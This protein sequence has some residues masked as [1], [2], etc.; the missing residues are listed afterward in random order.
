[1]ADAVVEQTNQSKAKVFISYSRKDIE[2][3][4]R[5]E[6]ALKA[7]GFE[8]LIDRQDPIALQDWSK[9]IAPFEDW[10]KRIEAL[11]GKADTIVFV[12][13]PDSVASKVALNEINYGKL[14]NKRFAPVV[15]RRVDNNAV[16]EA[17]RS[18][19]YIFFDDSSRFDADADHL[20][21]VL[22]VDLDWI[23]KHTEYGETARRWATAGRPG[24]GGLLLRSP[25]LEEAERWIAA[26]PQS[27]PAPTEETVAFV[28]ESRRGAIW[29]RRRAMALAG[30]VAL[31]IA[32]GL[33]A[34]WQ[35]VW[36]KE[37]IYVLADVYPLKTARERALKPMETFKECTDCPEMLM[38]PAGSFMM[39]SPAGQGAN[40]E[41]PQHNVTIANP[42]AL[43]KF[44]LTFD[45]WEACIRLGP[46][47]GYRPDDRGGRRGRR[48]VI[49]VS[50]LDAQRYVA[51]LAKLT[52]KPYRLLT[53][54]E[55]EYASRAGTRTAYPW[56]DDVEL[57]GK[58]M[59]NCDECGSWSFDTAP[60]G[61]FAANAFGLYDMVGNVLEWTEDCYKD[62]GVRGP[63][64]YSGAPT[65]G[66]PW[67]IELC[68]SRVLRGG[69]WNYPADS[70]RSAYRVGYGIDTRHDNIGF[71]VAR[72]LFAQSQ[73]G[74]CLG[75]NNFTYPSGSTIASTGP[76][77]KTG[78]PFGG[79]RWT[80][81]LT[82][83]NGQWV[84]Q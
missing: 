80:S 48:P 69:A 11:I 65:D 28:A 41:H 34:W 57:N 71:R 35:E 37:R 31:V 32:S 81:L 59:A 6:A 60:V 14:L 23:R 58:A 70:V 68:L 53:E 29:L 13:S 79:S 44:E 77:P 25:V 5:L 1:M 42:F 63:S 19:H 83:S 36:L 21:A 8:P 61:S 62:D 46:C 24:R 2:F 20:A 76:G 50:W 55:Y 78:F 33:L 40:N 4:D 67:I 45:E 52:G 84:P 82:C 18:L 12:L 54:A 66:L 30:A 10:W 73:T 72:T 51:W 43:A 39:G 15:C 56:G 17:L 74:S 26:R 27:A 49:N 47:E 64:N 3:A 9:G 7:R 75:Y 38:V 22:Q 16:P